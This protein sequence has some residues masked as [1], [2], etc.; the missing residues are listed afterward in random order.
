[1]SLWQDVLLPQ[2]NP[3][4]WLAAYNLAVIRQSEAA[5]SF[6]DAGRYLQEKDR[7]A[8]DASADDALAALD[9][10]DRLLAAVLGNPDTP[11]DVR[12]KAYDQ[13]A[14][15]DIT[16][17]RSPKSDASQ[18]LEHA[19]GQLN[20]AL[21]FAA[22]RNDPLP[23]YTMGLVDRNR[24]QRL[25][26]EL[27][28]EEVKSAA[29]R[30]STTRPATPRERPLLDMYEQAQEDFGRA[31]DLSLAELASPT[32]G[33]EAQRVLPL[34]ALQRGHMDW[35]LASFAHDHNDVTAENRYSRDAATDFARA[36]QFNPTSVEARYS[37]A[38]AEENLGDL[39][40]A[41]ENLMVILRYLDTL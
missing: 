40:A 7:D 24:A 30:P 27:G 17:L 32:I 2:K 9:D 19:A 10:S 28:K 15:N 6:D 29:K 39:A 34:A 23:Y 21:S 3:R 11:D 38:L 37:L 35:A 8:S 1:M 20:K 13:S 25:Q 12:Y 26:R 31:S 41:R 22:A 14:E 36:V 16:L 4:S 18:L 33:P 5:Q